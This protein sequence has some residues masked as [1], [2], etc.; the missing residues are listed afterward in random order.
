[1]QILLKRMHR[2][3]LIAGASADF[4][5]APAGFAV[6][7]QDETLI[8]NL[9]PTLAVLGVIAP[10]IEADDF[11]AAQ[12]ARITDQQDGPVSLVSQTEGQRRDHVEN[13]LGQHGFLLHRRA[14]VFAPDARQHRGDVAVEIADGQIDQLGGG[15]IGWK[16]A[17]GFGGFPDHPVQAFDGV[18]GV[19]DLP[20]S[21][22]RNPRR[23][24]L[25]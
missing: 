15:G 24:S 3:G 25:E 8:R 18:G 1:M 4:N 16:A 13:I 9:Y 11:R 2:A 14:G 22:V 20:V 6:K 21:M 7:C 19:D 5:L 12:A 10:K 17:T 23:L